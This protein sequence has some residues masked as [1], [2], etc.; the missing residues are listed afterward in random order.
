MNTVKLKW[1]VQPASTGRYRS[2]EKRGW[3]HAHYADGSAAAYISC[4]QAYRPD[5]AKSGEHGE[6]TVRVAEYP[7]VRAPGAQA[8]HWRT[9][10]ARFATLEA[11]KAAAQRFIDQRPDF[12]PAVYR[13]EQ[14]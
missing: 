13:T 8:F 9:I 10:K 3:P 4:E 7:A 1:T 12:R 5:I 6:L 14:A 11:A 2:F